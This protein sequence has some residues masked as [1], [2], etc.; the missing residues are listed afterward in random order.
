L[1]DDDDQKMVSAVVFA[2][3]LANG[4]RK[5]PPGIVV[6]FSVNPLHLMLTQRL[7]CCCAGF[8]ERREEMRK[9]ITVNAVIAEQVNYVF[10]YPSPSLMIER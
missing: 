9:A 8:G 3:K 6:R 5:R 7:F 10:Q 4:V 2:V 1:L